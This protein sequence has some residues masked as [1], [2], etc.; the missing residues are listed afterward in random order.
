V[1]FSLGK[2]LSGAERLLR[3]GIKQLAP[4]AAE[5]LGNMVAPGAGS[6]FAK[7]I[8][9]GIV[10]RP[11]SLPMSTAWGGGFVP[12][13][14]ATGSRATLVQ[15]A[16]SRTFVPWEDSPATPTAGTAGPVVAGVAAGVALVR[17]LLAKAAQYLGRRVTKANALDLIKKF[18]PTA[19]ASALGWTAA[20]ALQFWL[21]T[22]GTAKKYRRRGITGRQL[23]NAK[24]VARQL[25]SM[26]QSFREVCG[27]ATYR[28]RR[29]SCPPKRRR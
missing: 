5:S 24:R 13:I 19:A 21:A 23:A 11:G 16:I 28:P 15:P 6:F 2:I 22:G 26:A 29:A 14:H 27:S 18:G 20:E 10:A 9:S 25:N 7:P 1:G 3:P 17:A 4:S 8:V 12:D